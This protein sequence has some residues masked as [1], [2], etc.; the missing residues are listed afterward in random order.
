MQMLPSPALWDSLYLSVE[1]RALRVPYAG[2]LPLFL[3]QALDGCQV[4]QPARILRPRVSPPWLRSS[5][6]DTGPVSMGSEGSAAH[7]ESEPS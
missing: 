4:H 7:S 1:G 6:D 3:L 2:G 5:Q